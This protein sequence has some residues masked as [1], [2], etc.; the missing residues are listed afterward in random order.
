MKYFSLDELAA[1][2][3]RALALGRH[4]LLPVVQGGM[5]VGV[6][7]HRLASAVARAG[8][9]GTIASVDLR[10]HHAD[11]MEQFEPMTRDELSLT[12]QIGRADR[13]RTEA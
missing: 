5:G 2:G 4:R 1:R 13:L 11:L 8:A 6:S 12:D 7:A 10:H 9:L 3:L